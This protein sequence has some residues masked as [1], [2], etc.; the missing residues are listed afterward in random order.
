[1]KKVTNAIL[2]VLIVVLLG[3][4]VLAVP[5]GKLNDDTANRYRDEQMTDSDDSWLLDY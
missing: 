2:T 1:M 4:L 5:S 3:L